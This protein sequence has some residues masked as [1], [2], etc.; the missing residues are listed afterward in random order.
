MELA[1]SLNYKKN[2][3]ALESA[4]E[5]SE[6]ICQRGTECFHAGFLLGINEVAVGTEGLKGRGDGDLVWEQGDAEVAEEHPQRNQSTQ[7]TE[8]SGR[9]ISCLCIE[10]T[11]FFTSAPERVDADAMFY[12]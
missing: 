7:S 9:D 5:L 8:P 6:L 10:K 4:A 1:H 2:P 3:S 12:A 11:L